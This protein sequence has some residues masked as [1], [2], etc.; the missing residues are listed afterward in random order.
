MSSSAPELTNDAFLGGQL[1]LTQPA[2]GYRAGVDPVFL[3]A[4]IPAHTGQ[5]VLELGCGA[6][7]ASLCLGHRVAGLRLVGLERQTIYAD[8][9]RH[10][11]QQNAILMTVYQGDLE[12]MPADLRQDRFDHLIMNPPYFRRDR[13]TASPN[14]VR[15]GA[16]GEDTPLTA[17]L[18]HA[19]RRLLPG[20]YMTL[21]QNAERLPEVLRA[22]DQR[23]GSVVVKPLCPRIGRAASLVIVQARKGARGAFRLAAPLVLHEGAQHTVDREHYTP[24]VADILR[25]GAAVLLE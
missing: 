7:A 10:N 1:T 20:G 13:G 2:A 19:T 4:A 11:A 23:L 14:E 21:I 3:A 6:G 16:L 25:N 24:E 17:W 15:E 22:M 12:N 18:D 9:A 8:L 5:S